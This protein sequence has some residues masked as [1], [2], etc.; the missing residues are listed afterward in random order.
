M[1]SNQMNKS[2][3]PID[4]GKLNALAQLVCFGLEDLFEKLE[5]DLRRSGKMY[6]GCWPI[7]LGDNYSAINL[8]PE[9]DKTRGIRRCNT[10]QC[11]NVFQKTI[12]GFAGEVLS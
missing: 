2:R 1:T 12:I 7:Q 8:Y 3:S 4:Y 10:H 6:I 9:G 5:I 11:H